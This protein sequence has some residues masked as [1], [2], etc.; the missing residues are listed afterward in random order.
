MRAIAPRRV[1]TYRRNMA[2]CL[3]NVVS[4]FA[5]SLALLLG[6]GALHAQ[7]AVYGNVEANDLTQTSTFVTGGT[8]GVY[9]DFFRLLPL[10]V[11]LDVRGSTLS[12]S[13]NSLTKVL[14]GVRV[15]V[16]PPLLPI[17]PYV[18]FDAGVAKLTTP[19]MTVQLG[20]RLAYEAA[21]G[22]D[23][24]FLPHL[25]WRAV[26]VGVGKINGVPNSQ[27]HVATGLVFRF[28]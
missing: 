21:G 22:V 10:R 3:Q 27:F 18:Q 26:E 23:I 8:F 7:L 2:K 25:D 9:D 14:G 20:N 13:N 17:K 4:G 24:T 1:R 28:F 12:G 6:G 16:K 19:S 15:A 11:G 5:V